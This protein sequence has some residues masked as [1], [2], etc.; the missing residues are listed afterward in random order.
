MMQTRERTHY[1]NKISIEALDGKIEI[2]DVKHTHTHIA[3]TNRKL[4]RSLVEFSLLL[5]SQKTLKVLLLRG[6]YFHALLYFD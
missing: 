1:M 3:S 6:L 5:K 4:L 2:I